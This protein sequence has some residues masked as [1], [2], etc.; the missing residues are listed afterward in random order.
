M[1]AINVNNMQTSLKVF[2]W[3]G[4]VLGVLALF[5]WMD[6]TSDGAAFLGGAMFLAWGIVSLN[7][8]AEVTKK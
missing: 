6:N 3:T 4:I 7:Y 2:A 8:I 5:A 1:C